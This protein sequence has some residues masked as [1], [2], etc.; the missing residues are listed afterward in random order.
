[1]R[2]PSLEVT[3][4]HAALRA[5]QVVSARLQVGTTEERTKTSEK[6]NN[7][8]WEATFRFKVQDPTAQ[9]LRVVLYRPSRLFGHSELGWYEVPLEQLVAE[10]PTAVV[11]KLIVGAASSDTDIVSLTCTAHAF[12][13]TASYVK[14]T[15][16]LSF[17]LT[18]LGPLLTQAAPVFALA[19]SV[20]EVAA[21]ILIQLLTV[22]QVA[23]YKYNL[24]SLL[25]A[26]LG[27]AMVFMGG[28]YMTTIAAVEAF[29]LCGWDSTKHSLELLWKE[30]RAA[31]LVASQIEDSD[32]DEPTSQRLVHKG[33]ARKLDAALGAIDP[34]A[35]EEGFTGLSRGTFAVLATLRTRFAHAITLGNSLAGM[36][37]DL[38]G[39]ALVPIVKVAI[40][41]KYEK[42]APFL[43]RYGLSVATCSM[44]WLLLRIF[45]AYHS[46]IYGAHLLAHGIVAYLVKQKRLTPERASSLNVAAAVWVVGGLGFLWQLTTGFRLPFPLNLLLLPL[47]IVEELLMLL[48]NWNQSWL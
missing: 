6:T 21:P 22:A 11:G 9:A 10:R 23:W 36:G 15:S 28:T 47:T 29:R 18:P 38:L 27:L 16:A 45:T 40:P 44:A 24:E 31:R 17:V 14:P 33:S 34:S 8:K 19:E 12:G 37:F 25:P 42:W 13:Q 48:V 26:F 4:H 20:T 39:P 3:L 43:V 7:P 35:I 1:M 46:A 41:E 2:E 5:P 32:D 30:L